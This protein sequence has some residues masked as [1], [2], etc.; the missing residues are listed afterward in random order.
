MAK[1]LAVAKKIVVPKVVS[2]DFE[3]L[4]I[5]DERP[6]YPPEPVAV[7]IKRWKK[8]A[9]YYAWG[10][11]ADDNNCTKAQAIAALKEVWGEP[12]C[13][14]NGK[15]DLA[16]AM[17]KL[18]LPL[19]PFEQC[20]DTLFVSYLHDP[21]AFNLQLKNLAVA[22]C[23]MPPEERD[24][25]VEWLM[26]NQPVEGVRL[27]RK[28]GGKNKAG[29]PTYAGAYIAYAPVKVAG[30]YAN[31]DTK[32]TEALFEKLYPAIVERGMLPAYRRE[33]EL[34][35]CL[36]DN[37]RQGIRV[38]LERLRSDVAMY[39]G[40]MTLT[41]RWVRK[42]LKI[43]DPEA[44]IGGQQLVRALYDN[45][46]VDLAVLGVTEKST[47]EKPIYSTKA[48][49]LGRA[50]SDKVLAAVLQYRSKLHTCLATFMEN[51]LAQA[52][53]T[54]GLIHTDWNQ[55]R[56]DEGGGARTGRLSSSPNFQNMPKFFEPIWYHEV[57]LLLMSTTDP[58][59]IE[60]LREK[61]ST[62][63]KIPAALKSLPALPLCRSYIIPMRE[64]YIL[65]GRDF[66]QQEI[67]ILAHFEE[68]PMLQA[69]LENPWIDF[70]DDAKE[71]LEIRYK[72]QF[73]RKK[74]KTLNLG[75]IYG[76]GIGK[77]AIRNGESYE[78]TKDL[79]QSIYDQYPGLPELINGLKAL[80][81]SG[82]PF[83]TWGGREYTCE[84]ARI[85]KGKFRSFDYK[86]LNT[87]IQGSAADCTKAAIVAFYRM[88]VDQRGRK[89]N[90]W[91]VYVNVHDEILISVPKC[92]L[93][94]AQRILG[95]AMESVEF[96]LPILSEGDWSNTHWAAMRKYDR[97][98]KVM[99][100]SNM[101]PEPMPMAAG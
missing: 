50:V 63:P 20:H 28:R 85:V 51:W 31:G 7:S 18:G 82:E 65:V 88:T 99:P 79:R 61:L 73:N 38:D 95:Q 49:D 30:P 72:K 2:I 44:L 8:P 54:G 34:C 67:R 40:A 74:V 36:M 12:I 84:P 83:Y 66:S 58:K 81:K 25:V 55:V 43:T 87:L 90:R 70:H 19:P 17:E 101:A 24:V 75:I 46:L 39:Q 45:D 21:Q 14:H 13:M 97:K 37:E 35:Q 29:L 96:D 15:F 48:E 9:K 59:E 69:Y 16:V 56:G 4:P 76:M 77:M 57:Q 89:R 91:Y 80:G 3:T 64:D 62:T 27:T 22:H 23:S 47:A 100:L 60:E 94:E 5:L 6:H 52:E 1:G 33:Q 26:E 78:N 42:R 41:D 86:M 11:L 93:Q 32:R 92:D 10:H 71:K 53:Q 98:G 68:G